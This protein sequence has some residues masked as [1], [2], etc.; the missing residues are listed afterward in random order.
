MERLRL[1]LAL[2]LEG[3]TLRLAVWPYVL[4]FLVLGLYQVTEESRLHE[5]WPWLFVPA[6]VFHSL[7]TV[8]AANNRSR[9]EAA[10]QRIRLARMHLDPERLA[11]LREM[12]D[13]Q[14]SISRK[15]AESPWPT[16]R[17]DLAEVAAE[18]GRLVQ[19]LE[20]LLMRNQALEAEL[21]RQESSKYRASEE[22]LKELR[23][24]YQKQR[25]IINGIARQV[26]TMDA[27]ITLII[28]KFDQGD[29]EEISQQ[30]EDINRSL[31][32]WRQSIQEVYSG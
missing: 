11:A 10:R 29:Q 32:V 19:S 1:W 25:S 24:L 28:H 13:I 27:N 23:A 5:A 31:T 26:A 9:L 21:A 14:A 6:L 15:V 30:I 16:L 4:P 17:A 2:A 20:Q 3:Q 7:L 18:M 12:R 8:N 22:T